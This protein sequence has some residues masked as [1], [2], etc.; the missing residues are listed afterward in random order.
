VVL[1]GL[2]ELEFR[3]VAELRCQMK[4]LRVVGQCTCG[5]ATVDL[6][7]D[8]HACPPSIAS[9]PIP[10]EA[11]VSDEAGND[12]GGIIVFLTE[13]YLSLLDIYS[14]DQPLSSFPPPERMRTILVDR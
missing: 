5:C 12:I 9:R 6:Q 4:S 13:G 1:G 11:I 3:G 8:K 7:A 10:A 14:Y 2:L